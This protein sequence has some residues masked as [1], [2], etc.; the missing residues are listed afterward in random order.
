M[1]RIIAVLALC[2]LSPA[3]LLA[4]EETVSLAPIPEQLD[5]ID[6]P[7]AIEEPTLI[8]DVNFKAVST[9]TE[10]KTAVTVF[11]LENSY[12]R[13]DGILYGVIFQSLT[14][15][16]LLA[17]ITAP[18]PVSL[19][20]GEV[21]NLDFVYQV[22][23]Y[24][25][26]S[27]AVLL[28]AYNKKGLPLAF[29]QI[30]T[31]PAGE[32]PVL[33]TGESDIVSCSVTSPVTAEVTVRSGSPH[34]EIVLTQKI[35]VDST[36]KIELPAYTASLTPGRYVASIVLTDPRSGGV[37]GSYATDFTKDGEYGKLVSVSPRMPVEGVLEVVV[38]AEIGYQVNGRPLQVSIDLGVCGDVQTLA[39][40]SSVKTFSFDTTCTGGTLTAELESDTT[41]LDSSVVSFGTEQAVE[42]PNAEVTEVREVAV[43]NQ[44]PASTGG[45]LAAIGIGLL[46]LGSLLWFVI[47]RKT[48]GQSPVPPTAALLLI[49]PLGIASCMWHTAD[50]ATFAIGGTPNYNTCVTGSGMSCAEPDTLTGPTMSGTVTIPDS[51]TQGDTY[52]VS[53]TLRTDTSN[54]TYCNSP[55]VSCA[56]ANTSVYVYD[57]LPALSGSGYVGTHLVTN[58]NTLPTGYRGS[59][60]DITRP[61]IYSRSQGT[62]GSFTRTAPSSG[63]VDTLTFLTQ[64]V[65]TGTPGPWVA[66]CGPEW[67]LTYPYSRRN[68]SATLTAPNVAPVAG[69]GSDR[70]ITLPTNSVVVSGATATD[71]DGTVASRVWAFVSG[72]STANITNSTTLTPTLNGL[73]TAGTYIFRLTVT[74]NDGATDTDTMQVVVSPALGTYCMI[75]PSS[76]MSAASCTHPS[77]DSGASDYVPIPSS[78]TVG[79]TIYRCTDDQPGL[80][81][82]TTHVCQASCA[83]D[84]ELNFKN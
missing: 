81:V 62:S 59:R 42:T 45:A 36:T 40:D 53:Y 31:L 54:N 67:C 9:S 79:S 19:L 63:T 5:S 4:Q 70:A 20:E 14:T 76:T 48:D 27:A 1:S 6:A 44:R 16:E 24:L 3:S 33:C 7:Q 68:A 21:K 15:G 52:T 69:A 51:V 58:Y 34:G 71:S 72:P 25:T 32:A 55:S 75:P 10:N 23:D 49:L 28:A 26:Q 13:Q 38:Y 41:V 66:S 43:S 18:D 35:K 12:G 56:A 77:L 74:D 22:P 50:A 83:V 30:D 17:S 2:L 47:R 8:A 78:C 80:D 65:G 84:V 11:S 46:I 61:L 39:L 64:P 73:T 37:V 57:T 29:A 60:G 82:K